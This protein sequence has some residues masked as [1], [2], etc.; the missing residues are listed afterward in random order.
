M[1]CSARLPLNSQTSRSTLD[2]P[3]AL[4]T[5]SYIC[6]RGE[7]QKRAQALNVLGRLDVAGVAHIAPLRKLDARLCSSVLFLVATSIACWVWRGTTHV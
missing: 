1:R 4:Y 2:Q 7:P 6:A 3:T 5:A